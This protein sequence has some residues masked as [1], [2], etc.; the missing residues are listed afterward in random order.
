M[1]APVAE[2][3]SLPQT[4]P[5]P[6]EATPE[7]DLNSLLRSQNVLLQAYALTTQLAPEGLDRWQGISKIRDTLLGRDPSEMVFTESGPVPDFTSEVMST[8]LG[9]DDV[10]DH[11]L[12]FL[13]D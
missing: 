3:D 11:M 4:E 8:L 6:E 12:I 1:S 13:T 9:S 7:I 10:R 5:P 2:L